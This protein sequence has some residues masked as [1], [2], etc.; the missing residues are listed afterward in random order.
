M[1]GATVT[2]Y[3]CTTGDPVQEGSTTTDSNGNFTFAVNP[4]E[5]YYVAVSV[6]GPLA[7]MSPAT[8]SSNPSSSLEIGPS[9]SDLDFHFE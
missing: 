5:V 1:S 8:D 3:R 9:V 6:S 4:A 2:L 7:G